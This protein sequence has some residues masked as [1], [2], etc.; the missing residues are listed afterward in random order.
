M[1]WLVAALRENPELALFTVLAIGCAIGQVRVGT[2]QVGAVLGSLIAGLAIGQLGLAVPD[3]M[4]EVFFLLFLFAVGLRN[5]AEFFRSLRANGVKQLV[6]T[7]TLCGTALALTW[8]IARA[9]DL[10]G[11][12]AAGLLAGAMTNSTV[13]GTA[14]DAAAGLRLDPAAQERLAH[15]LATTYALTYVLGL[16]LIM[17]FLPHVG[18][19]LMRVNLKDVSRD[20][21]R[22][23]GLS[24]QTPSI[25]AGH[26]AVEV[27]GYRLPASFDG[28]TVAE[29]EGRWPPDHR[30]IVVRVRRG[31]ALF[32]AVP[33]MRLH[34]GDAVALGGRSTALVG[35][36]NPLEH[37]EF[38]DPG[39]LE[40]PTVSA[41]L[42]LTNRALAGQTLRV[43]ADRLGARGIFLIALRRAGR[44]LPFAAS[45]PIERG[46][47]LSVSGARAEIARVAAEVGYAEYPTTST[48][49]L[50][51]ATTITLGGLAGLVPVTVGG[52]RLSLS[53]SVGVLLA[54]LLL[55]HLRSRHPRFGR[56]PEASVRL[57]ETMGLSA[58][59]ASVG[60][61]AG[62]GAIAAAR[63]SGVALAVAATII[64]LV[65]N[66]VGILIG[67]YA[68]G[69]HPAIVL[70][71]CA[72]A[73]T[74]G[75]T[76]AALEQAADS[77]VPSLGYGMAC[78]VGN[79]VVAIGG[80]LLVLARAG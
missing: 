69:M 25:N 68:L 32:D 3:G 26:R 9:W 79:V 27:R 75:P 12:T 59:L 50:L 30:A 45:T 31:E 5:G 65:P 20:L 43:L 55:G 40:M 38:H 77:R 80:A 36:S 1:N 62:P 10:D 18:P 14:A 54:G 29:L 2:F 21:E 78:A 8:G 23:L 19:R 52:L 63:E 47:V 51:V 53:L 61:Q 73:G 34:G 6:L 58:F 46:D 70:G 49:L 44:E 35:E 48:D 60:L 16:V 66:L 42:L 33:G 4:K 74:S 13:L 24:A 64:V 7:L 57:F 41:D 72:G 76:L 28:L 15:S 71:V 67:R 39:L 56:V 11:G 22:S 37:Q 17:W